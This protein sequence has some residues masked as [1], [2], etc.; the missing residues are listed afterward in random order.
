M[1]QARQ[2]TIRDLRVS[3]SEIPLSARCA[4]SALKISPDIKLVTIAASW[5]YMP[6][7][8]YSD[9][10]KDSGLHL[11]EAAIDRI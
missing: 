4:A 2:A 6:A 8:I 5:A 1:G 7:V 3:W 11:I 10:T 9:V